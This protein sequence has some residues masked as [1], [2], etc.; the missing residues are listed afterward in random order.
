[1]VYWLSWRVSMPAS[2]RKRPQETCRKGHPYTPENTVWIKSK[3]TF[4]GITR[5]C[6]QCYQDKLQRRYAESGY[7]ERQAEKSKQWRER[8][9]EKYRE[10]YRR[11]QEEKKQIL[12]DAR[13]GGCIRCGEKDPSCLD[14]HHRNGKIDKLGHIGV[15]RK[16]GTQRLLNEIA[17]CDV[18]CANCHRK[19]HRDERQRQQEER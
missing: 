18:L 5:N 15:F 13:Q 6:R 12:L 11:D 7:H 19:Y 3:R 9:P 4:D 8:H 1:M 16:F 14:F 17:K 10:A 2:Y